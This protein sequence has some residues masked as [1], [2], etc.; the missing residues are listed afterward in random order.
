MI[1]SPLLLKTYPIYLHAFTKY[2]AMALSVGV[3]CGIATQL[4]LN[5]HP[6]V[7][8]PGVHA[9]YTKDMRDAIRALLEK[10]GVKMVEEIL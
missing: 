5:G 6:T 10:E 2:S 9:P 3:T 1:R 7:N 8:K 4:L